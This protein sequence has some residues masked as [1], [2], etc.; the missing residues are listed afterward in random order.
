M[1]LFF[2]RF[3]GRKLPLIPIIPLHRR[4]SPVSPIIPVHTQKQGGIPP[5]SATNRSIS[6]ILPAA[7]SFNILSRAGRCNSE[8]PFPWSWRSRPLPG[9]HKESAWTVNCRLT[10][11]NCPSPGVGGKKHSLSCATGNCCPTSRTCSNMYHYITYQCRRADILECGG[12]PPLLRL[13]EGRHTACLG[14]TDYVAKAGASSRTPRP[15]FASTIA[16]LS[17]VIDEV[18]YQ[19]RGADIFAVRDKR[20]HRPFGAPLEARGKQDG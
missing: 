10:T 6:E 18:S 14:G 19:W 5:H 9:R 4:H 16:C 20:K 3:L 11:V 17:G 2:L 15:A 13:T 8:T 7:S 12:S 1:F